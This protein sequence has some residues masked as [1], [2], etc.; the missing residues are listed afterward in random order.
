MNNQEALNTLNDIRNMMEKS[1]RFVSFSG[2]SSIVIGIYACIA[3][4]I[5]YSILGNTTP[6]PRLDVDTP[7]KLQLLIVFASLL[8]IVCIVT[9]IL[10]CRHKAHQNNQSLLFDFNTKRLLWNFFLP[11]VVGG[12]LCI[13]LIWQSHYGLTSSIMLIFYGVALISAS[14]YTFSNT[15]YLVYKNKPNLEMFDYALNTSKNPVCY[16]GD[17]KTKSDYDMI[18]ERF[19]DTDSIMIGRG[20]LANPGLFGQIRGKGAIDKEFFKKYHQAIFDKFCQVFAE[21]TRK[22]IEEGKDLKGKGF[23]PRK[24]LL[25]GYEAILAKVEEKMNLFGSVG[26]A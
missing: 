10:M 26:K 6:V 7:A 3:A 25:P 18:T 13:S 23:D 24:L 17:I 11:L 1:T 12:I 21:A 19:P 15:R 20:I 8:I 14:N 9:V 22:Y 2:L 5:A 16:N 4:I